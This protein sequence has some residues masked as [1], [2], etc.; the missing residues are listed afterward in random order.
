MSTATVSLPSADELLADRANAQAAAMEKLLGIL[1]RGTATEAE[2]ASMAQLA[3][4]AGLRV[5]SRDG[6][7][8]LDQY[9]VVLSALA[10]EREYI[11][12]REA[13]D[14]AK[15][16]NEE[17]A[18]QVAKINSEIV[19][20][21][22]KHMAR[23]RE[24][25]RPLRDKLAKLAGER[26][27]MDSFRRSSLAQ[28]AEL[29]RRRFGWVWD[30]TIPNPLTAAGREHYIRE[31]QQA[32]RDYAKFASPAGRDQDRDQSKSFAAA[33]KRDMIQDLFASVGITD[34]NQQS[35]R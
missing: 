4:D 10:A 6:Y 20:I 8:D 2:R 3:S 7:G 14:A 22:E 27:V 25:Q 13:D 28:Q 26:P 9:S 1:R 21:T 18:A 31:Y 12:E 24:E 35:S 34:V 30:P 5:I 32:V 23:A 15:V 16:A 17:T 33:R 29:R 19:A 11:A